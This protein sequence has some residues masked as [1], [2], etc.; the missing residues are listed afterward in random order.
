[1][2][3]IEK[4]CRIVH[5][6]MC[7]LNLGQIFCILTAGST[8]Q[9]Y[10]F[11]RILSVAYRPLLIFFM[12]YSYLQ[13]FVFGLLAIFMII[14]YIIYDKNKEVAKKSFWIDI[15]LW[16]VTVFELYYLESSFDLI[17]WF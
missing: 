15:V 1:M 14:K 11:F 9:L 6:I 16:I 4:I 7:V 8:G 3:K 13:Y 5:I 2:K 17:L 12:S 10:E